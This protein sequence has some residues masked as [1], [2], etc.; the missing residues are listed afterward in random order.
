[1]TYHA[2][3]DA[4]IQQVESFL[5]EYLNTSGCV[6]QEPIV[7]AMR[8]SA[9]AGG[10]RLRPVFLLEFC[11]LSGGEP[12]RA[13]P[14]A[15]SLEM[16]HTYSLIHDDLPC[17]DNDD[18]RRGKPT[19]HKVYGEAMAVLAGDA[20]LTQAFELAANPKYTA[21]VPAQTAIQA[22][23]C[24]AKEAG[25][26]GMIGGQVLDLQAEGKAIDYQQLVQLQERKTGALIRAAAQIGC[27]VGG[28]SPTQLQA[29]TQY[30]ERLGLAFQIQDDILDIEGDEA[31]FGKPIGSDAENKKSTFPGL[32][33]LEECH[34]K[35]R[36]LTGEAIAAVQS[37]FSSA[38]F[39]VWLAQSLVDRKK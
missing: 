27:I 26:L 28:A 12:E 6:G 15:V 23:H 19:N 16:I 29:A 37:G 35:V 4:Y 1:M 2:Q 30:A 32:L 9:L 10:K 20:L 38:E 5:D 22:V 17:M 13:L 34:R 18:L 33:G 36:E 8:Y 21:G 25:V 14:F 39:L 24:L 7:E 3:L 11:R 31:V